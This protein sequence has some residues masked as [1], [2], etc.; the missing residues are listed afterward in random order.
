MLDSKRI[1]TDERRN[2]MYKYDKLRGR[3][4]EKFGSQ[5]NFANALETTTVTVSKKMT[6]KTGFSQE[7][8]EQW[9]ELLDIEQSEYG[10]YFFT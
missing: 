9:S 4:V 10:A 2:R 1:K 3:I 7:D 8:I 6:G 5:N